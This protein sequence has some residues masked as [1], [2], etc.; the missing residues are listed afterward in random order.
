MRDLDCCREERGGKPLAAGSSGGS[1]RRGVAVSEEDEDVIDEAFTTLDIAVSERW[2]G[3]T[4]CVEVV[5]RDDEEDDDDEAA[6]E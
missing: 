6:G 4:V 1:D 5:D 2:V 3:T